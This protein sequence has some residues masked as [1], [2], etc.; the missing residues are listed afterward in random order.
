MKQTLL[1]SA[2]V[3]SIATLIPMVMGFIPEAWDHLICILIIVCGAVGTVI[4]VPQAGS[5]WMVAYK[6]ISV[7]GLNF[8]WA[9]NHL[10]SDASASTPSKTTTD[11]TKSSVAQKT[12]MPSK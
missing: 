7:A 2:K 12:D 5:A 10:A 8:G 1:T 9:A 11:I 4:P 3:S 6:I